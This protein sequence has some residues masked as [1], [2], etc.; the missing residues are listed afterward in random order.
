MLTITN[1]CLHSYQDYQ[2]LS[3]IQTTLRFI[4]LGIVGCEYHF[5]LI[6]DRC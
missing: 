4:P 3:P 6:I 5:S 2:L 1:T